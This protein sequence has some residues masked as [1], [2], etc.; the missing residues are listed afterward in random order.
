MMIELDP[1]AIHQARIAAVT[2]G[3][4][5]GQWPEG[6]RAQIGAGEMG[7]ALASPAFFVADF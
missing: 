2:R 6:A 7:G 4:A 3:R 5:V 1:N